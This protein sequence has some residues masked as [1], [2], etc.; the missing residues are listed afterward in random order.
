VNITIN[1]KTYEVTQNDDETWNWPKGLPKRTGGTPLTVASNVCTYG[2]G[3]LNIDESRIESTDSQLAEKYASVRNA[4]PRNNA[5]YGGDSRIRSEGNV[6]PHTLGRFPANIVHDGSDDVLAGFPT[7]A[8]SR[9]GRPRTG[10][11]GNGWGMTATGAEY[12]D[13]GSAARF[14]KSVTFDVDN[15]VQSFI[16]CPKASSSERDAGLEGVTT[17]HPT[18][19]PI[20]LMRYLV[21]LVTPPGG[22]VLDPFLGSGT[23]AVAAILDGFDWIGCEMTKEYWPIIEGRVAWAEETRFRTPPQLFDA[24]ETK[25][26]G[27]TIEPMRSMTP[28]SLFDV[29]QDTHAS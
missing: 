9:Q 4:G 16:Y 15:D 14:F 19:K 1:D 24:P 22:V 25:P 7:T 21:K 27:N 13:E 17:R 29:L 12:D 2:T 10:L 20:A 18:V 28:S 23:T 5:I 3:A 6:E 26:S 11:H 8:P